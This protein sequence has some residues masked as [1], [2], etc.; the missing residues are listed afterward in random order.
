MK[1]VEIVKNLDVVELRIADPDVE[2]GSIRHDSRLCSEWSLFVAIKGEKLDGNDFIKDAVSR[3]SSAVITEESIRLVDPDEEVPNIVRVAD[4][5]LA[6]AQS[7]AEFS[8]HPSKKLQVIGITGT[9]GKTTVASM[10]C[11]ILRAQ[12]SNALALTTV[13]TYD[14][15]GYVREIDLTT[16]DPVF[17]QSRFAEALDDGV[18]HLIL[19]VSSHA[20][21]QHRVAQTE[22]FAGAFTNLTEDHL[23]FHGDMASYEAAKQKFFTDYLTDPASQFSVIFIDDP[24]GWRFAESCRSQVLTCSMV[25]ST[26]DAYAEVL[27]LSPLGSTFNMALDVSSFTQVS[28]AWI[29]QTGRAVVSVGIRL[30]GIFNISNALIASTLAVGLGVSLDAAADGLAS[31]PGVP[32]RM[33]RIDEGQGF[34]VLVDYAHTPDALRNVLTTLH[35]ISRPGGRIILVMGNGGERDRDKRPL[36]GSIGSELSDLL[37]LTNDNPRREDPERILEDI[38]KGIP[39]GDRG[40]VT[41][42]QDRSEAIKLA[43]GA[44]HEG[45]IVII[46]GKGHEDYQIIGEQKYP[47]DDREVA[48]DALILRFGRAG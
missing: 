26:A 17:L 35:Q 9:N 14:G 4:S 30:P 6:L 12:G 3:G 22:F 44:A 27:E 20:L 23:D 33:E 39:A 41:V 42:N 37:F 1:L 46:A 40:K 2:I 18:S 11:H 7:A 10:L 19:E 15:G 47:F 24:V 29:P 43:I 21:E 38:Q 45:D 32:G 25:D 31:F 36:C 5:R 34:T 28:S 13:G 8:G 16:P 48:R